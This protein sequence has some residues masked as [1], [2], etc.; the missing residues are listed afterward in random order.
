MKVRKRVL[1]EYGK[2]EMLAR[3]LRCFCCLFRC[4][5][6]SKLFHSKEQKVLEKYKIRVL[7]ADEPSNVIWHN[8]NFPKSKKALRRIVAFLLPILLIGASFGV[9]FFLNMYTSYGNTN[10]F[11]N[12]ITK[13]QVE[14]AKDILVNETQ[15]YDDL[16]Y[17]YCY[18]NIGTSQA[19]LFCKDYVQTSYNIKM[20]SLYTGVAIVTLN[21]CFYLLIDYLAEYSK[22]TLRM[23]RA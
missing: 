4:C 14:A 11:D 20:F 22:F 12:N 9:I 2:Y 15:Q 21:I 10:C 13:E 1:Q 6:T 7:K 16:K 19:E 17:C 5:I 8:N 18:E 23:Q 3:Y